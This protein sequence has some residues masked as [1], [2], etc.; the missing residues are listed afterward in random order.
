MADI[1]A[2]H[3]R[4]RSPIAAI[5]GLA[6]AA[7]LRDDLD[8]DLRKHLRAIHALAREALQADDLQRSEQGRAGG[9]AR[10]SEADR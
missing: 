1:E 3:H 5:V 10:E 2:H 6:E 8:P 9:T 7:L 4:Y